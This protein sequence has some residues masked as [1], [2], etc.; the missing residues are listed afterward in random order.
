MDQDR[1]EWLAEKL[2]AFEKWAEE[3][4]TADLKPAPL[5]SMGAV[6]AW[7]NQHEEINEALARAVADAR[8]RGVTWSQIGALLGVSKQ[9]AHRKYGTKSPA[10]LPS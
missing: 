4:D 7:I 10:Q 3:V 8:T 5:E 6:A 9:A 2:A 1:E